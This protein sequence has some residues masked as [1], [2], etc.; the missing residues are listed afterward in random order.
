LS[1]GSMSHRSLRVWVSRFRM[2]VLSRRSQNGTLGARGRFVKIIVIGKRGRGHD[3][4]AK[5][6]RDLLQPRV[7]DLDVLPRLFHCFLTQIRWN[8]FVSFVLECL[9]PED[10][11]SK[12]SL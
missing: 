1:Q 3:L 7:K 8:K 12:C 9:S 4:S 6:Q 5:A 11:E 2:R 10:G